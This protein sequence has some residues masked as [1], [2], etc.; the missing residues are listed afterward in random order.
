MIVYQIENTLRVEEFTQV[1]KNSTLGERRPIE[2]PD[3]IS[4]N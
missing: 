3:R 4:K 2:E 1:L